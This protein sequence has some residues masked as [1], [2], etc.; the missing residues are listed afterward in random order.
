MPAGLRASKDAE[1]LEQLLHQGTDQGRRETAELVLLE[2]LFSPES[3]AQTA[4]AA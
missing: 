3:H 1:G 2:N 4:R